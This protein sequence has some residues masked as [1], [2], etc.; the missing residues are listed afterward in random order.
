MKLC[1]LDERFCSSTRLAAALLPLLQRTSRNP[2]QCGE[3]RLGEPSFQA[4]T[5][6]GR[7]RLE[8]RPSAAAGFDFAHSVQYL[9]PNVASGLEFGKRAPFQFFTHAQ[10]SPLVA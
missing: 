6:D 9:L 3:L 5:R 2:E 1:N 4:R 10:T 8:Y 7:A